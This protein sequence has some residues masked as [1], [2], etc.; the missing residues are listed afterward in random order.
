MTITIRDWK[1]EDIDSIAR[2]ANDKEIAENLRNTFPYPYTRENAERYIR[3]CLAEGKS[4]QLSLAIDC[5]G[6]AVGGIGLTK[7]DDIK[8]KCAELGYWL[9]KA[10]WGRGVATQAVSLMCA[11]GF[12]ELDLVRIYA[13]VFEHNAASQRVLEK[14]GFTLEGRLKKSICKN[15]EIFDSFLY[16]LTR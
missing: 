14:C 11:K 15:G 12:T 13:E 10:Y 3:Y 7:E 8:C 2:H 9:G 4:C 6:E 1:I 5:D 16:A